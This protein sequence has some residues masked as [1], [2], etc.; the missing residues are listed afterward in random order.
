[1]KKL[2]L[3]ICLIVLAGILSGCILAEWDEDTLRW[4]RIGGNENMENVIITQKTDGSFSI[5]IGKAGGDATE[6]LESLLETIYKAGLQ[7][8]A[9]GAMP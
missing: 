3:T 5:E 6:S 2:I 7:A 1:M 8:G 4:T 9:A